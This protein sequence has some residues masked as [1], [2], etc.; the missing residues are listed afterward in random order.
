MKKTIGTIATVLM[1]G[2]SL[3][4][5]MFAS[6]DTAA[7]PAVQPAAQVLVQPAVQPASEIA[8]QPAA[9]AVAA[10]V[11]A[12]ATKFVYCRNGKL[13]NVRQEPSTHC[14]VLYRLATGTQVELVA[15]TVT[16]KGWTLIRQE[17]KDVGWVRTKFLSDVK[18]TLPA[19]KAAM[20]YAKALKGGAGQ[21]VCLRVKP[22]KSSAA[23]RRLYAG[24]KLTIISSGKNWTRVHDQATGRTGYVATR[25]ITKAAR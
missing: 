14:K 10:P 23:I 8:V 13:L 12:P 9:D 18:R 1:M 11:I 17:G 19:R 24:N 16:A 25:Y 21:S 2:V 4:V 22:S 7:Q 5:P 6:A 15:T 3:M 20:A